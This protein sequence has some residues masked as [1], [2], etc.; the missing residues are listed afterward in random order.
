[1]LPAVIAP[2]GALCFQG[3]PPAPGQHSSEAPGL[4][5]PSNQDLAVA[6][7]GGACGAPLS[8]GDPDLWTCRMSDED[9]PRAGAGDRRGTKLSLS[10]T[11][12]LST[13][14]GH[15]IGEGVA[16]G[17]GGWGGV[18]RAAQQNLVPGCVPSSKALGNTLQ[19]WASPVGTP[20]HTQPRSQIPSLTRAKAQLL[21]TVLVAHPL[22][23]KPRATA[24]CL[25]QHLLPLKGS[26]D[27]GGKGGGAERHEQ[28]VR[29]YPPGRQGSGA[30]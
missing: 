8:P 22:W 16:V 9:L 7:A 27:A 2:L 11:L 25:G 28:K 5:S 10:S 29:L 4:W 24:S 26:P 20:S 3:T 18:G 17:G 21:R 14:L 1:M 13:S 12:S 30:W 19:R 15:G 6:G 23:T